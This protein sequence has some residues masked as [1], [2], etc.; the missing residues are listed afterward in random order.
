MA[1]R[2]QVT[3]EI[4]RQATRHQVI[5][6]QQATLVH[7]GIRHLLRATPHRAATTERHHHLGAVEK[8]CGR[9]LLRRRTITNGPLGVQ[10]AL[11]LTH[12]GAATIRGVR[13]RM[14]VLTLP[15]EAA[16]LPQTVLVVA[17]LGQ[18]AIDM[19][20]ATV[21]RTAA[22]IG[23]VI[24]AAVARNAAMDIHQARIRT[25][26]RR[27]RHPVAVITFRAAKVAPA[28]HILGGHMLVAHRPAAATPLAE[29]HQGAIP[30][31]GRMPD[32]SRTDSRA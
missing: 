26:A 30:G 28:R 7:P 12:K 31:M 5:R 14:L 15:R 27:P 19:M 32:T 23:M 24:V 22:T 9:C 1:L 13:T 21:M 16:H 17:E 8:A 10:E 6:R 25:T 20:V 18:A 3:M 11:I 2:P 4:L 29:C